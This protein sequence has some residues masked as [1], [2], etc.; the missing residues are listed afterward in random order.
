MLK[1]DEIKFRAN[2]AWDINLGDTKADGLL[3]PGGDNIKVAVAGKYL[4]TL[5]LSVG[6]NYTY[7]LTKL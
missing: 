2:D 3:E 4:V 1:Q 7:V 6:G 5:N